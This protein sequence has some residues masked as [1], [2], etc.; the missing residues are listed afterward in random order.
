MY[1]W[2]FVALPGIKGAPLLL[3]ME[4]WR[5]VSKHIVECGGML[6]GAQVKQYQPPTDGDAHWVTGLGTWVSMD[7]PIERPEPADEIVSQLSLAHL[8]KLEAAIERRKERG[9]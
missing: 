8:S 4:F 6:G 7:T 1:L 3:P 5:G 9:E 2:M